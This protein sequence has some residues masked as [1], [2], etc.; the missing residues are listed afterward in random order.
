MAFGTRPGAG[1]SVR[2]LNE[3]LGS[4]RRERGLK[5]AL[6]VLFALALAIEVF[7][8]VTPL[9]MQWVIDH[10]LISA[11]RELLLTLVIGFSMLLT[12]R[13][14]VTAMRGWVLLTL[15]ASLRVQAE[16]HLFSHL[17]R[18]PTAFF[19]AR[20]LGD[21]MSRFGSQQTILE[22]ITTEMIEAILDGLMVGLTLTILCI[23]APS[24]AV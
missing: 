6:S 9:F 11:D 1:G 10:V 3:R 4:E 2:R 7:A 21:V 16:T 18:L 8:L 12:I 13:A 20:H 24:L 5:R 22:A 19:E 14:A 15:G 17:V 23:Y